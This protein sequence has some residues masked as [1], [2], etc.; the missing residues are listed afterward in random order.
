MSRV[1]RHIRDHQEIERALLETEIKISRDGTEN[2][3]V[4]P[5]PEEILQARE[6][7]EDRCSVC[8]TPRSKIPRTSFVLRQS[9][10]DKP[11]CWP[12]YVTVTQVIVGPLPK[13]YE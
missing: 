9:I 6:A 13:S 5:S 12:C 7:C 4:T 11:I 8:E 1:S 3:Y 10:W 2:N